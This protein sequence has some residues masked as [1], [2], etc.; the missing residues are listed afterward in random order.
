MAISFRAWSKVSEAGP[1]A[2]LSARYPD[3]S[4]DAID[5]AIQFA[6]GCFLDEA[7][8]ITAPGQVYAW[9]PARFQRIDRDLAVVPVGLSAQGAMC[10]GAIGSPSRR[11]VLSRS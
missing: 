2:Q 7:E 4:A 8:G 11:P 1:A 9:I 3:C 10:G 6:C 5:D